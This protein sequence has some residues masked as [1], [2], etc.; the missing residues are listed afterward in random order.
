MAAVAH[1]ADAGGA[2]VAH[3][4]LPRGGCVSSQEIP[5]NSLLLLILPSQL[6]N[7]IPGWRCKEMCLRFFEL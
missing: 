6:V 2:R 4:I 1:V 7:E 5:V 3:R